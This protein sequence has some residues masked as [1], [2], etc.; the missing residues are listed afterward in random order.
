MF[1]YFF[2]HQRPS[3]GQLQTCERSTAMKAHTSPQAKEQATYNLSAAGESWYATQYKT[4][5]F[6]CIK[7][8]CH[9][10][11]CGGWVLI[12]HLTSILSK[13]STHTHTHTHILLANRFVHPLVKMLVRVLLALFS[14]CVKL[15]KRE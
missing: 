6:K 12:H 13:S 9:K 10:Y 8:V 3:K 11:K 4:V 5:V 7:N 2:P 1:L 14:T 15:F